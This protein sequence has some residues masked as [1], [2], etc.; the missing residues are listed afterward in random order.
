[1]MYEVIVS[2]ENSPT[3]IKG[4]GYLIKAETEEEAVDKALE[5]AYKK[6]NKPYS[7]YKKCSFHVRKDDVIAKPNW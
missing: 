2:I 6:A 7:R 4:W 5:Y 3:S 1:M